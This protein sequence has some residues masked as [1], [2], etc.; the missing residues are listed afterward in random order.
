MDSYFNSNINFSLDLDYHWLSN[1]SN[2][3]DNKTI[4]VYDS[5]D[6]TLALVEIS[7]L[8]AMFVSILIGNS[9]VLMALIVRKAKRSRMY[10]YLQHLCIGDLMCGFFNVFPQLIWDITYR[11]YGGNLL[12]KLIKYLQLLGPYLSSYILVITAVDRYQAI[13]HPLR[14]HSRTQRSSQIMI[15]MA[16]LLS[17]VV[18]C[19][20]LFIFSYRQIPDM[21]DVYDCWATFPKNGAKIYVTLVCHHRLL[22]P[23]LYYFDDSYLYLS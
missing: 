13:C 8:S 4:E 6:E 2:D 16:W 12:C 10:Y 9:F 14:N 17:L 20:Q 18:C 7:I 23:F 15:C 21:K 5:R 1:G 19:P 3:F 22:H 11:F